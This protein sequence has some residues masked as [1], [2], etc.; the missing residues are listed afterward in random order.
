MEEKF[1]EFNN[2][3]KSYIILC[4]N[5][6]KIEIKKSN[7]IISWA[8][9]NIKNK[10]CLIDIEI[11]DKQVVEKLLIKQQLL[12]NNLICINI[13]FD[14]IPEYYSLLNSLIN[15]KNEEKIKKINYE[16]MSSGLISNNKFYYFEMVIENFEDYVKLFTNH[17]L[18]NLH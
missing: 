16:E 10:K 4:N 17:I 2:A 3:I 8:N 18:I 7:K 12:D 11:S 6:I 1:I 13:I 15:F 5:Q 14:K 9:M